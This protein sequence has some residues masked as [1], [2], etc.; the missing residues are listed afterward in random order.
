M[1]EAQRLREVLRARKAK[2]AENPPLK[3][4]FVL[5]SALAAEVSRLTT[6]HEQMEGRV[7]YWTEQIALADESGGRDVR[8]SG[9][10]TSGMTAK[11]DTA[12]AELANIKDQLAA[13][14]EQVNQ[15]TFFIVFAPCGQEK[16]EAL[17]ARFPNADDDMKVNIAFKNAL[18]AECFVRFEKDDEPLDL[19]DSWQEFLD[20]AALEFGELDPWRTAVLIA[21]NRNPH[22]ILPR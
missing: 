19:Y 16:Y 4:P 8:A 1:S 21:C 15:D 14:V 9:H 18:L 20:D 7:Q 12:S 17:I 2:K 22:H 10:D 5:D 6:F 11:L 3:F 13:A